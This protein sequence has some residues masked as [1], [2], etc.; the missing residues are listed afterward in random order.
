MLVHINE[1]T[2]KRGMC[3]MVAQQG[4]GMDKTDKT[5]PSQI[6]QRWIFWDDSCNLSIVETKKT[7]N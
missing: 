2:Y 5:R 3:T 1:F 7:K 4:D 6:P